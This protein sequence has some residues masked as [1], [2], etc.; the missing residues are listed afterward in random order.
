MLKMQ[1]L[2]TVASFERAH[3]LLDLLEENGFA[4]DGDTGT[5]AANEP[6]IPLNPPAAAAPLGAATPPT[7]SAEPIPVKRETA[8]ERKAREKAEADAAAEAAEPAP[9]AFLQALAGVPA[10]ALP[11]GVPAVPGVPAAA[12]T[13]PPVQQVTL[14]PPQ[15][16]VPNP[17]GSIPTPPAP[18]VADMQQAMAIA[19]GKFPPEV[20]QQILKTYTGHG[21]FKTLIEQEPAWAG[22]GHYV[23]ANYPYIASSVTPRA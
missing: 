4:V 19:M 1:L 14:P 3:E 16:D 20:V 15:L 6:N 18:T 21:A 8:K 17:A 9:P 12:P 13:P 7:A 22:I 2:L 10:A 23:L 11:P 5:P